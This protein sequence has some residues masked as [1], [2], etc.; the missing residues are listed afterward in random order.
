MP[1]GPIHRSTSNATSL[2]AADAF[3]LSAVHSDS[4]A[5][6]DS[7]YTWTETDTPEVTGKP[8]PPPPPL[9]RQHGHDSWC[10]SLH[11]LAAC[12]STACTY[13]PIRSRVCRRHVCACVR[14]S[15]E[16]T[17]SVSFCRLSRCLHAICPPRERFWCMW[18]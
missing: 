12:A 1:L 14:V 8:G 16:L 4:Y 11:P 17:P 18:K 6:P 10:T 2:I 5:A 13:E 15:V 3:T 7:G 9:R